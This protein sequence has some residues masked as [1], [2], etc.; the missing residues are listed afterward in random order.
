V[1]PRSEPGGTRTHIT[2]LKT[3]AANPVELLARTRPAA[4]ACTGACT[5]P[6]CLARLAPTPTLAGRSTTMLNAGVN[7]GPRLV[8]LVAAEHVLGQ[9][10]D[11]DS[12]CAT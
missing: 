12:R 3:N 6:F 2:R 11:K 8:A 7:R 10:P 9:L 5:A 1:A 4:G